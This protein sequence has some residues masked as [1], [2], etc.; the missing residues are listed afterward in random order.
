MSSLLLDTL[1]AGCLIKSY[2][3]IITASNKKTKLKIFSNE[4]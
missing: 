2:L 4:S 3:Y 1:I